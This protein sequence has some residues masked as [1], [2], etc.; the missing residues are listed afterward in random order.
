MKGCYAIPFFILL[1]FFVF[2]ISGFGQLV[3]VISDSTQMPLPGVLV[4]PVNKSIILETNAKGDVD[5]SGIPDSL[6]VVFQQSPGCKEL[7]TVQQIAEQNF[8]IRLKECIF[9]LTETNIVFDLE[10]TALPLTSPVALLISKETIREQSYSSAA[11]LLKA[12][13]RIMV[14]K[15]QA[16]GGSPVLRGFEANKLL[17]AIDGIRMNNAIYRSGHLQN[18]ITVDNYSLQS[19]SVIQGPASVFY[20]SG[21]LGGV[22]N[23]HTL[24]PQF[25][26]TAHNRLQVILDYTSAS[27]GIASHA[28]F[29]LGYSRFS[30]L[31]SITVKRFGDVRMGQN[32]WFS[33]DSSYGIS[34]HIVIKEE[35]SDTTIQNPNTAIQ[36]NTGY[37]Q[38]DFMQKLR[39]K[40]SDFIYL[41][42]NFQYST[43]SDIDR[44]DKLNDYNG[45]NLKYAEWYYGPQNRLLA[46]AQLRFLKPNPV[47]SACKITTA[48]QRIDEDR[49]SRQFRTDSTLHQEEDVHVGMFDVDFQKYFSAHSDLHYGINIQY[50]KLFSTAYYQTRHQQIDA[51]TRYPDGDNY[52]FSA[53]LYARYQKRFFSRLNF[54]IGLHV[55]YSQLYSTFSNQFISMPF[56]KIKIENA[57]PAGILQ[58]TY[59]YSEKNEL[60]T[61]FSNAYRNP[62]IDDY[63]KIRIKAGDITIPN[64]QLKPEFIYNAEAGWKQCIKN[65]FTIQLSAYYTLLNDAIVRTNYQL[66]GNDSLKYDAG[67][68]RIIANTNA[69]S[70]LIWGMNARIQYLNYFDRASVSN[71]DHYIKISS[72]LNYTYGYNKTDNIP[73][74]HIPPLFGRTDMV[75][76]KQKSHFLLFSEY[77]GWK[78]LDN[79]SPY[80]E[81]NAEEAT[82]KGY[83][84]WFTLNA[85]YGYS[86]RN[87]LTVQVGVYNI[88]DI[89]YKTFASAVSAPGRSLI[90]KLVLQR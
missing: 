36:P 38:Y 22:I 83:P 53:S 32:R 31:T 33:V 30:S 86:I 87:A 9:T 49:V 67:M 27:K 15:T 75:Y 17:L 68:Y 55:N 90:F 76:H 63:G 10:K 80:G 8:T 26:D 66:Y 43:S 29:E 78:R 19:V 46:S 2:S 56:D 47:F 88:F 28:D 6:P 21:A 65:D 82:S 23:Y 84:A 64:N 41:N 13:G 69:T 74:G 72:V 24:E 50:D 62:N 7:Y 45:K 4:F 61:I 60:Y 81:D 12:S 14:Q 3:H 73:L 35:G 48:Y 79:F 54:S 42:T 51:Q 58:L 44:F 34:N 77:N 1:S 20:G 57:F 85:S 89:Q 52:S 25:S 16:G 5:I 40:L 59:K 18:A 11:D 71:F 39:L 37:K 70:G